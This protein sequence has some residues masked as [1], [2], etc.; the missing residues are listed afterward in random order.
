MWWH[1]ELQF[2]DWYLLHSI[3]Q[4]HVPKRILFNKFSD[5]LN[6]TQHIPQTLSLSISPPWQ[7][8]NDS[9]DVSILP[10]IAYVILNK[11]RAAPHPPLIHINVLLSQLPFSR[12][13]RGLLLTDKGRRVVLKAQV[14]RFAQ[15]TCGQRVP[16]A[17]WHQCDEETSCVPTKA[18]VVSSAFF[19]KY[20]YVTKCVE[21]LLVCLTSMNE[22]IM[23]QA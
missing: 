2:H 10:S 16:C 4:K 20:S 12:T 6:K 3:H 1:P 7:H 5:Q 11:C 21:F 18:L 14:F 23:H 19:L 17:L 9:N 15:E 13:V 22:F 8:Y